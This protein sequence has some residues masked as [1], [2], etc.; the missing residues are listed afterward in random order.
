[1]R[2]KAIAVRRPRKVPEPRLAGAIGQELVPDREGTIREAVARANQG[3]LKDRI[4]GRR[5]HRDLQ[6]IR[7][8]LA[9]KPGPRTIGTAIETPA[10]IKVAPAGHHERERQG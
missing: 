6:E 7:A 1:M 10:T 2:T 8:D 9:R 4:N 5:A 3:A